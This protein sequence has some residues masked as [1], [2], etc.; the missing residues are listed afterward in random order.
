MYMPA[1]FERFV[2]RS[3]VTVMVRALMEHA[4]ARNDLDALFLEHTERQYTRELLFSSV[5][6]LMSV[7]VTKVQPSVHSAL[8]RNDG[9]VCCVEAS[10]GRCPVMP[11]SYSTRP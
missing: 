3:P 5:V 10:R 4:L 1:I 2:K 7:V 6:D 9:L 11:S 8:Q